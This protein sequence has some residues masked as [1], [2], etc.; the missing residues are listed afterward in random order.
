MGRH[1]DSDTL[2]F[3]KWIGK[4]GND[5][6]YHT[7][8]ECPIGYNDYFIDIVWKYHETDIPLITFE[9]ETTN[10]NGI[11]KNTMKIFG[12]KQSRVQKPFRHF[13]VV[14][15]N[16][17]TESQKSSLHIFLDHFNISLYEN[18]FNDSKKRK[19]LESEL[20]NLISNQPREDRTFLN[21]LKSNMMINISAIE[22]AFS[23]FGYN[24]P[25]LLKDDFIP[26]GEK[27][28]Y[29]KAFKMM[30]YLTDRISTSRS[31]KDVKRKD[32]EIF[33]ELTKLAERIDAKESYLLSNGICP[34]CGS[35]LTQRQIYH[36]GTE[37]DPE[38]YA[39][40]YIDGCES[41]DYE[42]NRETINM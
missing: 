2:D 3:L 13:M 28:V 1:K 6:G 35:K 21:L 37:F 10:R 42:L 23:K 9:V 14:L 11:F 20:D 25:F 19:E 7:E 31:I 18:I 24:L 32:F 16:S 8:I 33:I 5:L 17:L 34:K 26:L 27:H 39:V 36:A 22:Y 40:T 41:C 12:T 4:K 30:E 29:E 15:K 38:P